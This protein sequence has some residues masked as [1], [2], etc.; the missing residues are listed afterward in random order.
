MTASRPA[1]A[2]SCQRLAPCFQRCAERNEATSRTA[3]RAQGNRRPVPEPERHVPRPGPQRHE[4]QHVRRE[5]PG[6]DA[7]P[8][9][10]RPPLGRI[11]SRQ[12]TQRTP[13]SREGVGHRLPAYPMRRG[14]AA[15]LRPADGK[16]GLRGCG[17]G[18]QAAGGER[19]RRSGAQHLRHGRQRLRQNVPR[20]PVD[21]RRHHP[22]Q[23]G[24]MPRLRLSDSISKMT[25]SS[26]C[27]YRQ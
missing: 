10:D 27:S 12:R 20:R 3:V 17:S 6:H 16:S 2:S 26:T 21:Q 15:G 5:H 13:A 7:H 19:A 18:L 9:I 14:P 24:G 25:P 4:Q 8:A 23:E 11:G 1:Y 22:S